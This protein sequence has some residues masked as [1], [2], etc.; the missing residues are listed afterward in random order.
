MPGLLAS[1]RLSSGGSGVIFASRS[2]PGS[3]RPRVALGCVRRYSSP[4][5]PLAAPSVRR[6]TD[7]GRPVFRGRPEWPG[8][9]VRIPGRAARRIT[10]RGAGHNACR[11]A[12]RDRRGGRIGRRAP[13]PRD[14]SRFIVPARFASKITI[15]E[16]AA[17]MVAKKTAEQQS[18]SGRSTG[19]TAAGASGSGKGTDARKSALKKGAAE[20]DRGHEGG[21]RDTGGQENGGQEGRREE[22]PPRR[23]ARPREEG[24]RAQKHRG[25]DGAGKTHAPRRAR[26]RRAPPSRPR[27]RPRPRRRREPRR[28]LRRRLAGTTT[29]AK[30]PSAVPKAR[31]VAAT[32]PGELAVRPGED[33]WTPEEVGGGAHRAAVRGAAAARRDHGVRARRSPA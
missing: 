5:T 28:W 22:E 8:P 27:A 25:Q 3:H 4:S 16:G 32:E 29:A 6:P 17:A 14:S 30:K 20:E 1:L 11:L 7:S 12:P 31:V 26:P 9:G 2:P 33:P 13:L 23:R 21:G 18:A 15:C 10:R 24:C 19:S